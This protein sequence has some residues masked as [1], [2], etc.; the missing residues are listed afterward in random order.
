[1]LVPRRGAPKSSS[2]VNLD[3]V[4]ATPTMARLVEVHSSAALSAKQIRKRAD[5]V[6]PECGFRRR[7]SPG[8]ICSEFLYQSFFD[9]EYTLKHACL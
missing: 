1:M 4:L 2:P 7:V 3:D 5:H 8:Q 6:V 9:V